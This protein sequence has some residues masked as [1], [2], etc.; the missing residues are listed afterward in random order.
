VL[1][2]RNPALLAQGVRETPPAG[3]DRWL[4]VLSDFEVPAVRAVLRFL[5]GG[6][7][8]PGEVTSREV[9][10][11]VRRLGTDLGLGEMV[12]WLGQARVQEDGE[13]ELE[14]GNGFALGEV[15]EEVEGDLDHDV[16][17]G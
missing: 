3:T 9:L 5:Y 6:V 13:E 11:Q 15:Q 14:D 2:A 8:E 16:L 4:V 10:G 7:F 1:Q 17:E 12:Q